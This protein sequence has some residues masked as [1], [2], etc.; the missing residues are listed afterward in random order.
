MASLT[1]PSITDSIKSNINSVSGTITSIS[2]SVGGFSDAVGGYLADVEETFSAGLDGFLQNLIETA[3]GSIESVIVGLTDQA[4]PA[5]VNTQIV[6]AVSNGDYQLA[7]DLTDQYSKLTRDQLETQYSKLEWTISGQVVIDASDTVFPEPYVVSDNQAAWGGA[8][9]PNYKFSYINS[10]EELQAEFKTLNRTVTEM[11]VHWTDSLSN[12]N[13]SAEDIHEYQSALGHDGIAYHF[14]IRRDGSLQRG[15]SINDIGEHTVDRDKL[16]VGVAFV[17]GYNAPTGTLNP[18]NYKSSASLT[19]EQFNT[20]DQL[21][22]SF[23]TTFPGGQVLGHNDIDERQDDPG[24]D[25]IDYCLT[26]FN[27]ESVFIDPSVEAYFPWGTDRI[28][29]EAFSTVELESR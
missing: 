9:S 1:P 18:E 27:K 11:I 5:A 15:R 14:V 10:L 6:V 24:F 16:S 2:S 25:V 28:D 4:V 22:N 26:R 12:K 29:P 23:Y 3:D 21:V 17:G 13:L 7:A 19:R 8:N 20:F